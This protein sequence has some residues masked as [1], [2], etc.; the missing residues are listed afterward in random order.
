VRNA[1]GLIPVMVRITC[2]AASRWSL[3]RNSSGRLELLLGQRS[4]HPNDFQPGQRY[5]SHG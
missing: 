2:S 1:V 4:Y 5:S 3:I